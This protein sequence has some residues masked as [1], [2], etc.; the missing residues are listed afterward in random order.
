MKLNQIC[1]GLEYTCLQGSMEAE[2]R[3]IVYDSRKL[4]KETM[5]V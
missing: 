2:V 1:N 5:F 3:D 4:A